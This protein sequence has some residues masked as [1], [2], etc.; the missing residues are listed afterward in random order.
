[1]IHIFYLSCHTQPFPGITNI[2]IFSSRIPGLYTNCFPQSPPESHYQFFRVGK[3]NETY[4]PSLLQTKQHDTHFSFWPSGTFCSYKQQTQS[5]FSYPRA[6]LFSIL[7][8]KQ[9]LKRNTGT[10]CHL[11][12]LEEFI[13]VKTNF[14][15]SSSHFSHCN[16][17]YVNF[18]NRLN[19]LKIQ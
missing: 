15:F 10:H 2:C 8:T 7:S 14:I 18:L 5:I 17:N 13:F 1:M 19:I 12:L 6:L 16:Q 3:I 9:G 4:F 11:L